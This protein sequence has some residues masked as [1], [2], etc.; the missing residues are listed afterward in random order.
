[1]Q[2]RDG[3]LTLC[4]Q[5]EAPEGKKRANRIPAPAGPFFVTGRFYGP[6]ASLIDGS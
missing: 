2:R 3:S 1:V 6:D 5:L 4:L